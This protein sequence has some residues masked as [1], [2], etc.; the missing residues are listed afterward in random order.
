M[1]DELWYRRRDMYGMSEFSP[2]SACIGQP[3][4]KPQILW[5]VP[6]RTYRSHRHS[7]MKKIPLFSL[8][9]R[10]VYVETVAHHFDSEQPAFTEINRSHSPSKPAYHQG[11]R[12][13]Q[14]EVQSKWWW[15]I[16]HHPLFR[17]C[18]LFVRFCRWWSCFGCSPWRQ[19]GYEYAPGLTRRLVS[20]MQIVDADWQ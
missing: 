15:P 18:T 7:E 6:S 4:R 5:F 10:Y 13:L 8:N 12:H 1:R 14:V 9:L 11:C 16:N 17:Y 3:A 19:D 20:G 2:R